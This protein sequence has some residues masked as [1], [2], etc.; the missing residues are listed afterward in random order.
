MSNTRRRGSVL[1]WVL[2]SGFVASDRYEN[3]VAHCI[4]GPIRSRLEGHY[5]NKVE[6]EAY[7][8]NIDAFQS[9]AT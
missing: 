8:R 1:K 6:L 9:A 4:P 7:Q 5:S 2:S 3:L